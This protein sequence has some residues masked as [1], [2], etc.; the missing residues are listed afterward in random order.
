MPDTWF[1]WWSEEAFA[2]YLIVNAVL[3]VLYCGVWMV[4]FR[5]N[6][7]FR[8]LVLSILPS[9]IFLLSGILSRSVLLLISSLLFAPAHILISCRNA[10][11]EQAA[12]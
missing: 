9:A 6:T 8:A 4:C 5:R 2:V 10:K 12:S 1:G 7:V 11:L 3:V